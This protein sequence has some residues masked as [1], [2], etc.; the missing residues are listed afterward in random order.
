MILRT[1]EDGT[2]TIQ[3]Q[4]LYPYAEQATQMAKRQQHHNDDDDDDGEGGVFGTTLLIDFTHLLSHDFELAEAIQNE[5]VR[6]EPFLQQATRQFVLEQDPTL[7]L[8]ELYFLSFFNLPQSLKLRQ[9]L[10]DRVGRLVAVEGT[11]TRTSEV[12]P[13]LLVG[14]FHCNKCGLEVSGIRQQFH[15]THPTLCR[16]PRCGN[17][18]DFTLQ[19]QASQFCDWQKLRVQE[20]SSE[21]PPGSMPRSINV[22]CRNEMVERIKGGRQVC[23]CGES[24]G[25]SRWQCA[26]ACGRTAAA[27]ATAARGRCEGIGGVW[28]QGI[29]LQDLFCGVLYFASQ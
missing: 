3:P 5:F 20:N 22:V 16:N 19:T 24:G 8:P 28:S 1:E 18:R 10:M 23:L 7:D 26:V 29:D 12:R 17:Q 27:C 15:Y 6:F 9:L 13:E 4:Y 21:I 11:I 25:D 14:A 2:T